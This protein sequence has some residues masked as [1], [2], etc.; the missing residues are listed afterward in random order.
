MSSVCSPPVLIALLV[1]G[2]LAHAV[3]Q[4]AP[5]LPETEPLLLPLDAA[6]T[7]IVSPEA[8]D[9]P[10][11][12]GTLAGGLER[13]TGQ[14]PAI[15]PD[16]VEPTDL[17]AGP[18]IVLGNL[19]DSALDRRLYLHCYDFTDYSWPSPGGHVVRTIR[20]PFGTGAH[21]LIVGGSD[22]AGVAGAVQALLAH[23]EASGPQLGYLNLV[24]LGEWADEIGGYTERFLGDDDSV[25]T[26][27]GGAGSWDYQVQIAKCGIGYLRTGDEAYLPIF[28]REL[29]YWFDHYVLN[30]RTDAPPQTHGFLN[31]ILSVW[32]L[33]RD[34]PAF[35]ETRH[36][37]DE[38]WLYVYRSSE[39]PRKI[40]REAE[41]TT[42]R[43]NHGTRTGL[44]AVYGGRFFLRRF[45]AR[46]EDVAADAREWLD[47]ADRYFAPQLTS[48]KPTEDS[49]GHQWAASLY[50]TLIYAM[51]TD[52]EEY[53][54]SDALRRA[55]ERALIAH[56]RG[57]GPRSY[58]SA[59]AVATGDTGFLS[60]YPEG[61]AYGRWCAAMRS[62]CDEFL[63][64]F[65]T[66]APVVPR[67]ELLGV[68]VAP[69][70][71]LWYDT[72]DETGW[73]PGDLFVV[74]AEHEQCFDKLSIRE[75]WGPDDFYLLLDGISGGQHSYQD[76][77]CAIIVQEGGA[78]WT[79][80]TG[81]SL[82]D[83]GT[84]I[85]GNGVAVAL[86]GSGPGRLHRYARLLYADEQGEWLA[87]GSA[88]EGVGEADWQRHILRRRGRWTLVVDR[89]V[90]R[91]GG[92]VLAER[93]WHMRGNVTAHDD[94]LV[95]AKI[96]G[97]RWDYLHLQTAGV[98]PAGMRGTSDRAEV[99]RARAAPGDAPEFATLLHVTREV[100]APPG[101]LSLR[102]LEAE[103][104]GDPP[105]PAG[106][107]RLTD[108]GIV[109]LRATQPGQWLEMPFALD[110]A[111]TGEVFV[112]LLGFTDRGDVRVLLDGEEVITRFAHR[113]G[114]VVPQRA[115]LGHRELSAGGH[116]LRLETVGEP[117]DDGKCF[118]GLGG[119]LIRPDG[120]PEADLPR[121]DRPAFSVA[122]LAA[123]WRV[124]GAEDTVVV[125][126]GDGGL[127]I[128]T[129]AGVTTIGTAPD[130]VPESLAAALAAPAPAAEALL[131]LQPECPTISPP[132][133]ELKVGDA[134]ITAVAR[135]ADGRVAA[136]DSAGDVT[137]FDAAGAR[138]GSA[139]FDSEVLALHFI[140][141][142]LM[143]G[144]DR[145]AL[146]RLGPDASQRWQIVIPYVPMPWDYWSEY[147]SRVRE[148][149][150]ADIT[151]DGVP[152][153]LIANSDRRVHAFTADGGELWKVPV[154][155]GVFTAMTCGQFR[156]QFAL[157]GGTSH[158]SIHGRCII[159][160]ADGKL[161]TYLTR[162]DLQSWSI[163][164][165]FRDMR[166]VDL[167]GDGVG[168]IINAVDTNCR[169]L[170]AYTQDKQLLWDADM[171]GAAEA[172]AIAPAD[173]GAPPTVYCSGA[174]G[175]VAA[176]DGATGERRW[177][178]YL[179]ADVP[180]LAR[181]ADGRIAA[182][183]PAGTVYVIGADGALEGKV[184]LRAEVSALIRPGDQRKDD[185]LLLGTADGRVMVGSR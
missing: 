61:E 46:A 18:V 81:R 58:L 51:V 107:G 178:C 148:I 37:F 113:A 44:D 149:T 170:V 109:V 185:V 29:R 152:E 80:R 30:L 13:L 155:W 154:E 108:L 103:C 16:G 85:A 8:G 22:S 90:V 87:C 47:I 119:L 179:G 28:A 116:V 1:I 62:S 124:D 157:F 133:R 65:C 174:A 10:A 57:S 100:T 15:V 135:G 150:S 23:V 27:V 184:E 163:P 3:A 34:H 127:A 125:V 143:V 70:D 88:L 11:I 78:T 169:Q 32:D 20:D 7:V 38:D 171:A 4:E 139:H 158:P 128:L 12:A 141:E 122:Q 50:D 59:C 64:A 73:N 97:G 5:M 14:R 89:V 120:A 106:I 114:T 156:G 33:I 105:A 123:G 17:G 142:D 77:N 40:A 82:S 98:L 168:E 129:N 182:V 136:A 35:D 53:F 144:E 84:V 72:I 137:I 181:T 92:E 130:T 54:A 166:Q 39:G 104:T 147:R 83:S 167:D 151:G 121:P 6:T 52:H 26:R 115:P 36:K 159:F 67:R 86:D 110:E 134:P 42:I 71:Q 25:W 175:Y 19:M 49:W 101:G 55:A 60:G 145:G 117:G 69:L 176:F 180:L 172:I 183:T 48:S 138:L 91:A 45:G 153:I 43:N 56:A 94:G 68:S 66:N 160:S 177:A 75:G 164:S 165:Q 173:E 93:H 76:A 41:R 74:T 24:E 162:A 79:S 132:W 112:D 2:L 63:R 95:A 131:P 102:A 161:V 146:T 118:V 99:V 111:V 21:A 140:G 96:A 126:V 9:Y 31:T